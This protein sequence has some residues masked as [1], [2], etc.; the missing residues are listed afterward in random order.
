MNSA[1]SIFYNSKKQP[2]TLQIVGTCQNCE[3]L[4][5]RVTFTPRMTAF[6]GGALSAPEVDCTRTTEHRQM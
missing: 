1:A 6:A 2:G 5:F 4:A 3:C